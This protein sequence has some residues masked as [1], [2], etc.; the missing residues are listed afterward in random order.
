LWRRSLKYRMDQA[1]KY[2]NSRAGIFPDNGMNPGLISAFA[3][4]GLVDYAKSKHIDIN[5][6]SHAELAKKLKLRTIH[7]SEIDTQEL[8]EPRPEF[9]VNTWSCDGFIAE[10][11]DPVQIGYGTHETPPIDDHII[12]DNML[13]INKRGLD[14]RA[15]SAIVDAEFEGYIIPHG[16]ANTLSK[17]L[18]ATDYRPSVY[19]VYKPAQFAIESI[20]RIRAN[21]IGDHSKLVVDQRHIASGSDSVGALLIFENGDLWWSGTI[22]SVA[23]VQSMNFKISGPTT[24]QVAACLWAIYN[25]SNDVHGFRYPEYF[26]YDDIFKYANKYLGRIVSKKLNFRIPYILQCHSNS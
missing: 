2:A 4:R 20:D 9:F 11:F 23:D 26:K 22:L 6:L 16:E 14:M 15:K 8:R 1:E 24:V 3:I 21:P 7:I 18:T 5:G 10:A 19:Y 13:I 17:Y 12:K 25:I